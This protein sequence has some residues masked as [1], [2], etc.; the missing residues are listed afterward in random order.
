VR[1]GSPGK[2]TAVAG[3]SVPLERRW[4]GG[5]G[6]FWWR[7]SGIRDAAAEAR[8]MVAAA[9]CATAPGGRRRRLRGVARAVTPA[10]DCSSLAAR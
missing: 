8:R 10:R 5:S 6:G 1:E 9:Q 2:S 3:S 4:Q 7:R